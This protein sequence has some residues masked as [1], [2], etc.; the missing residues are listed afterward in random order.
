MEEQISTLSLIH[1]LQF[2]IK[3]PVEITLILILS[4][5]QSIKLD[6]LYIKL[7]LL[8]QYWYII[9]IVQTL[10]TLIYRHHS[11]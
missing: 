2:V 3:V 9:I 7:Y 8:Y 11:D 6:D 5:L 1:S 4:P 10:H